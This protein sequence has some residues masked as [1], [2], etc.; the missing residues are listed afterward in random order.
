MTLAASRTPSPAC[1]VLRVTPATRLFELQALR[2][3]HIRPRTMIVPTFTHLGRAQEDNSLSFKPYLCILRAWIPALR[4][5][6]SSEHV[7]TWLP[8]LTDCI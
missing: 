1:G 5:R 3:H 8:D 6:D 4:A 7:G 2:N